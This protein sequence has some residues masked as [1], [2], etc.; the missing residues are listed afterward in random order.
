MEAVL[1]RPNSFKKLDLMRRQIAEAFGVPYWM[2]WDRGEQ[3]T[4]SQAAYSM[5]CQEPM[6]GRE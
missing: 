5:E 6:L 1:S 2:I 4:C 3:K